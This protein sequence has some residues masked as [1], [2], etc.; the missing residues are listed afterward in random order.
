MSENRRRIAIAL[1]QSLAEKGLR[2]TQV[3]DIV[4]RAKISKRTFYECF[5]DKESAFIDLI[6]EWNTQLQVA[7]ERAIDP[8]AGW[9]EQVDSAIDTYIGALSADNGVATTVSRELASLGDRGAALQREG[10]DMFA[11]L[12]VRLSERPESAALGVKPVTLDAAVLLIGGIRELVA[13][14]LQDGED[15]SAAAT[16]AKAIVKSVVMPPRP[17]KDERSKK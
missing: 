7:V 10:I 4:G 13:R 1:A 11:A 17:A 14:E 16:T 12:M 15:L 8:R 3:N 2:A 9:E 6:R 5:P